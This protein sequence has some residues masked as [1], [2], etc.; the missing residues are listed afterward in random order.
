MHVP[1]LF[2]AQAWH[3]FQDELRY[4][5][6]SWARFDAYAYNRFIRGAGN[7]A[8]MSELKCFKCSSE[9][10]LDNACPSETFHPPL[11]V[12]IPRAPTTKSHNCAVISMPTNAPTLVA[13]M[14]KS[15]SNA[16]KTTQQ[17]FPQTLTRGSFNGRQYLIVML[18]LS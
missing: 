17:Y 10:H 14:P 1:S 4:K 18:I 11:Q 2:V 12:F 16:R 3:C 15:V 8:S 9:G 7:Q 13:N 5:A 6:L